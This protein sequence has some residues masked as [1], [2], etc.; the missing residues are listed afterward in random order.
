MSFTTATALA[1]EFAAEAANLQREAAKV[2]AKTAHDT[3]RDMAVGAPVDTGFLRSSTTVEISADGLSAEVGPEAEYGR[4]VNDGTYKM[5][6]RPF[7][8][9]AAERNTPAFLAA[10]AAL[11]DL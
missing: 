5:A 7:V 6:P 8:D 9:Q 10:C 1:A 2:V 4:Y 3:R 11:A